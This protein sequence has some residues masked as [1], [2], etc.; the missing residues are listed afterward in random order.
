MRKRLLKIQKK[1]MFNMLAIL[2]VVGFSTRQN[3]HLKES[4]YV[5]S[6]DAKQGTAADAHQYAVIPDDFWLC[7][8]SSR[9]FSAN[10]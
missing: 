1:I 4:D 7:W 9:I 5:E 3:Y 8:H 2:N 10:W 6:Y